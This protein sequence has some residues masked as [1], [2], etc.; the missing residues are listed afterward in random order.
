MSWHEIEAPVS[1][2]HN[3]RAHS[4]KSYTATPVPVTVTIRSKDPGMA[5]G[6]VNVAGEADV[7]MLET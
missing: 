1:I 7:V 4:L 3:V 2:C 6:M 5:L